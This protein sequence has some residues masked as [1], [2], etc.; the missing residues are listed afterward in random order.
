MSFLREKFK[1]TMLVRYIL[2]NVS[3]HQLREIADNC[4][5]ASFICSPAK[6]ILW[7]V[8]ICINQKEIDCF[9]KLGYNLEKIPG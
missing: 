5:R 8:S 3:S 7:D 2:K 1:T 4:N 9:K 6:D